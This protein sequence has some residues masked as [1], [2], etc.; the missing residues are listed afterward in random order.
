MGK[1]IDLTGQRFGR[2]VVIERA[3][4]RKDKRARWKCR[5][6]CGNIVEVNGKRLRNEETHSCGCFRR[7]VARETKYIHGY[8]KTRLYRTYRNMLNRCYNPR[9]ERYREYGGRGIKVCSEW[10]DPKAF[11][12]WALANGYKDDLSIDRIDVNGDYCPENCRWVTMTEQARNR[13]VFKNKTLPV[14]VSATDSGR[15]SAHITAGYKVRHLGTFDT[16]EEASEAYQRAKAE[17]DRGP[18]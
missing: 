17:R 10:H 16:A 13:R 3:P 15:Y 8:R 11:C 5:C 7:D 1:L 2:L 12:E 4:N 18:G 14:G 9:V 6:D